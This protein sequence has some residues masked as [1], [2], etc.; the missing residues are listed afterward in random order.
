MEPMIEVN[1]L[2]WKHRE[3][4]D[5]IMPTLAAKQQGRESILRFSNAD[6]LPASPT[7]LRDINE[8]ADLLPM[9]LNQIIEQPCGA[10]ASHAKG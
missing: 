7:R 5:Q 1:A 3:V 6:L 8:I 10:C 9:R 2:K 4:S